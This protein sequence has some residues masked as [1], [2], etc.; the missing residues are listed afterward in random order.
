M[1]RALLLALP[2][3]LFG[4]TGCPSKPKNGE[5]KNSEDCAAQ[6]GYG[7]ICVEGRCQEC[8]RDTDCKAGFVCRDYRCVPRPECERDA[9]CP[10]G[11]SCI[12][13]RCSDARGDASPS[14]AAGDCSTYEAIR[15][16]FN[17]SSLSSEAQSALE[18]QA[19]C[20][21]SG[22]FKK[23]TVAGHADERG[24]TEYN[25]QLGEKRAS[26]VKKY[27]TNMGVDGKTL[28]TVSFGEERPA[29][30]GHDEAAWAENRRAELKPE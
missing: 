18:R 4:L 25:L 17:E 1:R 28:K 26:A 14:D 23:V 8:A 10:S 20:I 12:D 11:K 6:E 21:K 24:T 30:S 29:N 3:A 19:K 15:F 27:L 22:N 7:K 16:G 2:L 5:C 9:D 13:G